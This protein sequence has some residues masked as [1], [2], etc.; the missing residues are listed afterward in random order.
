M[1]P[2]LKADWM[3]NFC[4][5]VL[6]IEVFLPD[7]LTRIIVFMW[8][9]NTKPIFT[10]FTY[11]STRYLIVMNT[12]ITTPTNC[13]SFF[14]LSMLKLIYFFIKFYNHFFI[15][16]SITYSNKIDFWKTKPPT[17]FCD[18]V[19][20]CLCDIIISKIKYFAYFVRAVHQKWIYLLHHR[21]FFNLNILTSSACWLRMSVFLCRKITQNK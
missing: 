5:K 17:P 14:F 10:V 9:K 13:F 15:F 2:E 20:L 3:Y 7:Q 8:K 4:Y 1:L 16:T 21:L 18:E 19:V 6:R 12:T 11:P